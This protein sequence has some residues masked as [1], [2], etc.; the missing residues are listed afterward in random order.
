MDFSSF[1][2][3]QYKDFRWDKIDYSLFGEYPGFWSGSPETG[4]GGDYIAW[5]FWCDIQGNID[6]TK[7][8]YKKLMKSDTFTLKVIDWQEINSY[9]DVLDEYENDILAFRCIRPINE[10]GHYFGLLKSY[11]DHD[12]G[13]DLITTLPPP[14]SQCEI[15]E[16]N[17][18]SS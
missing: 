16:T 11:H 12:A 14:L 3:Q 2:D 15:G 13:I 5:K 17:H 8:N 9:N 7:V 1:T 4:Y 18:E 6:W 10:N